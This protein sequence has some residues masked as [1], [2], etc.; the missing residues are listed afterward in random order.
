MRVEA[1]DHVNIHTD[2]LPGT[3][4]FYSE[5]L[6]LTPA[7]AMGA[8]PERARWL[9]DPHG[10]AII[11]LFNGQLVP[12]PTGAID[13][14]ALRCSGKA[15]LIDRLKQ[16]GAQ[17]DVYEGFAGITLVFTR[18]PQNILLELRFLSE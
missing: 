13:H 16:R 11:H 9:L 18:D 2:D 8:G 12:G 15:E 6:G 14:L 3:I 7:D 17:C 1:F 10:N 5:V 4:G